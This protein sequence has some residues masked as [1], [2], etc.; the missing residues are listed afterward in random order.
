[1]NKKII[2]LILGVMLFFLG[3]LYASPYIVLMQIKN[4][5]HA[6]DSAKVAQYIDYPS[7]RQNFKAQLNVAIIQKLAPQKDHGFA[8]L[9]AMFASSMTDQMVE[10]LITPEAMNLLLKGRSFIDSDAVETAASTDQ[11]PSEQSDDLDYR[12]G[13]RSWNDF[14]ILIQNHADTQPITIS[15]VRDGLSWKIYKISIALNPNHN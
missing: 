12:M 2:S 6:G 13:Y 11:L 7:V 5:V 15:M 10:M 8:A 1:M 14:Q 4:A 3:Y 9:G